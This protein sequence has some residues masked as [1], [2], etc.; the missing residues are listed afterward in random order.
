MVV[1]CGAEA[2]LTQ[3]VSRQVSSS[4][5]SASAA[6]S[7]SVESVRRKKPP[8]ALP[9]TASDWAAM[10]ARAPGSSR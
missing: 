8:S 4:S 3:D 5:S 1:G 10:S 2:R 9:I 6:T 7:G